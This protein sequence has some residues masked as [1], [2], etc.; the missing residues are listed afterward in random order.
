MSHDADMSNLLDMA[1]A[2]AEGLQEQ[3]LSIEAERD[4]YRKLL[5]QAYERLATVSGIV[6]GVGDDEA[7][8]CHL[9]DYLTIRDDTH[10]ED[11]DGQA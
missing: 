3:M 9:R 10:E 6:F 4:D 11:E 5:D 7:A 8:R 2:Q 1:L